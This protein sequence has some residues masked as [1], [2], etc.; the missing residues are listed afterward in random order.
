MCT[1]VKE[2]N[3]LAWLNKF[4]AL[5]VGYCS[6]R[7]IL[8][9]PFLLDD[10]VYYLFFKVEWRTRSLFCRC[11]LL[12]PFYFLSKKAKFSTQR[13]QLWICTELE[14]KKVCRRDWTKS[15]HDAWEI[16]NRD[17]NVTVC[18][19]VRLCR[20]GSATVHAIHTECLPHHTF[21]I[22]TVMQTLPARDTGLVGLGW[23][24][25]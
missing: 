9:R 16:V 12:C 1:E 17:D 20:G 25:G 23:G 8:S 2:K 21:I 3:V 15:K 24:R 7:N 18:S 19:G 5:L 14:K 11:F 10:G 22:T 6:G 4:E 13:K